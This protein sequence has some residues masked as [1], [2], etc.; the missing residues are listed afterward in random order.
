M[1]AVDINFSLVAP[2]IAL[3]AGALVVL[4][5]DLV[6]PARAAVGWWYAAS[7]G[8]IALSGYYTWSLWPQ[9]A[10]GGTLSAYAGAFVADR[11]SLVMNAILLGTALFTVLLS[12]AR[13]EE[14]M[15]G[16][17]ALIL[18]A[19]M[20]MMVLAGA[21]NLMT[22]FLGL[23]IFVGLIQALI[24]SMLTLVYLTIATAH[25]RAHEEGHGEA[26]SHTADAAAQSAA[27]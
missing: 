3:A 21:G 27:H 8:A 19:A 13:S 12:S 1:P 7:L 4:V 14:D 11:F 6:L 2:L 23:E 17:L 22:V 10:G 15:S 26:T 25:E 9:V 20:G 18:W 16:Y 5:F 24:F